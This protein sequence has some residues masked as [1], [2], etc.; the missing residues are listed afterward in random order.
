MHKSHQD[1]RNS[2]WDIWFI[3]LASLPAILTMT[4]ICLKVF[5]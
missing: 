5:I 4:Y 1:N 3:L 2:F